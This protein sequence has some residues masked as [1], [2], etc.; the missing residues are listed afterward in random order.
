MM[1]KRFILMLVIGV[2]L[3]AF[4][5]IS[6]AAETINIGFTG[7]LSGGAA[8]FGYNCL[9]GYELAIHE[10]N[11]GG[12]IT[13][14]NKNYVFKLTAM[15]DGY[16]PADTVSNVRRMMTTLNPKPVVIFNPTSGGILALE[17]FN[18]KEGFLMHG[19]I[20]NVEVF[21]TGN[22]LILTS[23]SL[24]FHNWGPLNVGWE[25][26]Y[27]KLALLCGTHEAG[28]N[29]EAAFQRQW[30]EKGGEIVSVDGVNFSSVTDFYPF[31][32]KT[33]AKNPDAIYTYGPAEPVA[34]MVK[35][36]REL[37]FKGSF[38]FGSQCKLDDM[39]RVS[40]LEILN[41]SVGPSPILTAPYPKMKGFH[42]RLMAKYGEPAGQES[43]STYETMYIISEAMK[44]SG[45]VSDPYKIRAAVPQ[46][47]PVKNGAAKGVF[48]VTPQGQ[49]M[50]LMYSTEIYNNKLSKPVESD[51]VAWNRK[52]GPTWPATW[53]TAPWKD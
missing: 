30:K 9:K 35:Q 25:R 39:L 15:D 48:K 32:T 41:N 17:T 49:L 3:V 50:C 16:K 36:A 37:G 43:S 42:D 2:L 40:S 11:A 23:M 21:K 47:L 22:K 45:S 18:E 1:K 33:L 10:I 7:P 27:R 51:P 12:G 31:L 28:K 26:G 8:K 13:V 52:F 38:L 4:T 14:N 6:Y 5:S 53:P 29:A 19:Y 24:A 20:D 46:V 34:M 44:K